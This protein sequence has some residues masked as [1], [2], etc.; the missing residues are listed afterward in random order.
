[1]ILAADSR[2][3]KVSRFQG[4]QSF[5]VSRISVQRPA[6]D[7]LKPRNFETLKL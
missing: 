7:T 2:S 6:M 5:K 1:L 4:F 3:F